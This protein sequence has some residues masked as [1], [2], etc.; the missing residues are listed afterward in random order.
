MTDWKH[1][2]AALA[3]HGNPAILAGMAASMESC[4]ARADLSTSLR[5]AHFLAQC[6][7]ESDGFHTTLEY[8]SGAAYEGRHDLGNTHPGDGRRY[9]GRGVIQLTGRANYHDY[10]ALLGVD[11]ENHPEVAQT[12]PFAALIAAEFWKHRSINVPADANDV[13][14]VTKKINGGTNGL[15]DRKI[16]LARARHALGM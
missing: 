10:G 15:E 13:V 12:F 1:I 16:W 9:R 3:P 6:A 2:L 7:E 14:A 8:A 4:I 11:L 5:Q